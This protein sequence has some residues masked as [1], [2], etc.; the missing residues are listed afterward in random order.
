MVLVRRVT[1]AGGVGLSL[2][3]I[4]RRCCCARTGVL[5][6]VGHRGDGSFGGVGEGGLPD[7]GLRLSDPAKRRGMAAV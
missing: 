5:V 1:I 2:L 4:A 7:D 6:G 3:T